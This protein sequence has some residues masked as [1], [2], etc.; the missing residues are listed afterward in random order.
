MSSSHQ[1]AAPRLHALVPCAGIGARADAGGPKQ[2]AKVCGRPVVAHTIEALLNVRRLAR[3]VVVLASDDRAFESAFGSHMRVQAVRKGGATRAATVTNGLRHL[4]ESGAQ[5][6]DW[7]LVHDAARCLIEPAAVDRLIDACIADDVGG[8]LALPLGDTLKASYEGRVRR[9]LDRSD[10][11]LAQTPQMFRVGTLLR[12]LEAAGDPVTD[13]AS[14][15]EA[16]GL[17]PLLVRG[18]ATN[19]KITWPE[20]FAL[21]ERWMKARQE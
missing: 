20:E 7:V 19:F 3:V 10:K 21:A 2:Y 6:H 8:L 14:A 9:T 11:W 18:D 13:E 4:L 15:I 12:A 1:T 17:A 5:A 16:M